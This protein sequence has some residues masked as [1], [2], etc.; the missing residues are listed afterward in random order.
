M[1]GNKADLDTMREV[2]RSSAEEFAE[3]NN[4]KF[5]EL[6]A[7]NYQ[8]VEEAFIATAATI[9]EQ[10]GIG[11]RAVKNGLQVGGKKEQ[12]PSSASTRCCK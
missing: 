8:S 9:Y 7:M 10:N 1:I 12:Q 2:P 4:L 5:M 11:L 3:A 6:S